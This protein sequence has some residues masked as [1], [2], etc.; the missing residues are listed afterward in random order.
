MPINYVGVNGGVG[1]QDAPSTASPR[2][3]ANFNIMETG[4]KAACNGVDSLDTN[5]INTSDIVNVHTN[6][7]TKVPSAALA[8]S[9]HDSLATLSGK[10]TSDLPYIT[11]L[12]QRVNDQNN[13]SS[14]LRADIE[15]MINTKG[16]RTGGFGF[17]NTVYSDRPSGS[18]YYGYIEYFKHSDNYVTVKWYPDN[19][20]GN[21]LFIRQFIIGDS[22]WNTAWRQIQM[23]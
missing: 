9:D 14:S 22:G 17:G 7:T 4:I 21:G 5:K 1:W 12:Y 23:I 13:G 11:Q 8:K 15:Y 20:A 18:P 19:I 3:A 2:N 10:V 6:S 16:I